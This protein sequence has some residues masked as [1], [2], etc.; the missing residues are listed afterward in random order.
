MYIDCTFET[1]QHSPNHT[2]SLFCSLSFFLSHFPTISCIRM[3]GNK[4]GRRGEREGWGTA[5]LY[6]KNSKQLSMSISQGVQVND[7]AF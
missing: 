5:S 1:S 4:V 2:S 3:E 7:Y 6:G